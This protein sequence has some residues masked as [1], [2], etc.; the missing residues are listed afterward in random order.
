ME[1]LIKYFSLCQRRDEIKNFRE[2][3]KKNEM[4]RIFEEYLKNDYYQRF[5]VEKNIVFSAL[6]GEDNILPE[7]NKQMRLDKKYFDSLKSVVMHK[8][9]ANNNDPTK[10]A[11]K[12]NKMF[13]N[14]NN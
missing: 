7:L 3:L 8:K 9:G 12:I 14:N 11:M 1:K 6:I 13:G 2:K 4:K 10:N 5:K